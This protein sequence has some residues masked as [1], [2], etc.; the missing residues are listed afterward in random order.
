MKLLV[1]ATLLSVMCGSIVSTSPA[2]AATNSIQTAPQGPAAA[3]IIRPK[4]DPATQL[5]LGPAQV[6]FASPQK[7]L[8]YTPPSQDPP[9]G[10]NP[11]IVSITL[12]SST[13][14]SLF[15][16]IAAAG[17]SGSQEILALLE[18][19][20]DQLVD[21]LPKGLSLSEL[22]LYRFWN[23]P[24]LSDTAIFVTA[25]FVWANDEVHFAP[26]RYRINAYMF[27]PKQQ[28]YVLRPQYVTTKKYATAEGS[29]PL[30]LLDAEQSHI[31]SKL[32]GA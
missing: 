19:K 10:L 26:H 3:T 22:S 29:T 9:F 16:A 13:K 30:N 8:C 21:L 18:I 6:C 17:G 11:N 25:N 4:I 23:A 7:R 5:P 27:D 15:T 28:V 31:I 32:S 1:Q 24:A 14:A 2:S 12:G 20:N